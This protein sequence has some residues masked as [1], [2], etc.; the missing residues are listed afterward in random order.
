MLF[1]A[2]I[3]EEI[4]AAWRAPDGMSARFQRFDPR[5]GGGYHMVMRH[6]GEDSH[7]LGKTR[8]GEDE[9]IVTFLE[10]LPDE[11]IVE[12]VEFVSDNPA[13]EGRMTLTTSFTPVKDGTKVMMQP[14]NV[15]SGIS[16]RDHKDGM[17]SALR[18][19][20]RLTE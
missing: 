3:D 8:P 17:T 16:A 10:L 9:V 2:F 12:A 1:R 4:M 18:N 19:L 5:I 15:P 14:D 13:F 6:E 7:K 20:A 11:R